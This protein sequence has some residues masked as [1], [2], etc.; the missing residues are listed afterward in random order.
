[1]K[2]EVCNFIYLSEA[3]Y[4][5]LKME[6]QYLT[7][8]SKLSNVFKDLRRGKNLDRWQELLFTSR[9]VLIFSSEAKVK[10]Y[11]NHER[12]LLEVL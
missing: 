1:M 5:Q 11:L 2:E 3:L 8:G 10:I 6:L 4:F 12:T 7:W 9:H